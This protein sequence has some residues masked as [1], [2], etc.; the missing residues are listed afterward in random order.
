VSV[1]LHLQLLFSLTVVLY[2]PPGYAPQQQY[3]VCTQ[4]SRSSESPAH[5]HI[6]F[7]Q[8]PP[9]P[10][11]SNLNTQPGPAPGPPMT[12]PQAPT[13]HVSYLGIAIPVPSAPAPPLDLRAIAA[14]ATIQNPAAAK[15]PGYDPHKDVELVRKACKGWGTNEELCVYTLS[16]S[17]YVFSP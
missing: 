4:C 6:P 14:G 7:S 16:Y 2:Q 3:A 8:P 1:L 9:G 12:F 11:P 5:T 17:R 13:D 15:V 10:P